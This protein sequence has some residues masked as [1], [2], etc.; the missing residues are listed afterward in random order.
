[1]A[2]LRVTLTPRDSAVPPSTSISSVSTL[3]IPTSAFTTA[4]DTPTA[5]DEPEPCGTTMTVQ[6]RSVCFFFICGCQTYASGLDGVKSRNVRSVT[7]RLAVWLIGVRLG[8]QRRGFCDVPP[9]H[10]E[11]RQAVPTGPWE[12]AGRA[13]RPP[14]PP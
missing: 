5:R 6:R 2:R 4:C 1:M 11:A 7:F 10:L 9:G 8:K 13:P 14:S 3:P 12:G